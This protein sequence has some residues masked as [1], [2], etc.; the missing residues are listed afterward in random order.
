MNSPSASRK[1]HIKNGI[2]FT[3]LYI[4]TIAIVASVFYLTPAQANDFL[5]FR[6]I[7]IGFATVLLAKYFVYMVASPWYDVVLEL[8]FNKQERLFPKRAYEPR[9]SV[10]VPAWNEED[11]VITTVHA[12]LDSSYRNMEIIVID[13]ASTDH[14]DSNV[15]HLL[16]EYR[17]TMRRDVPHIDLVYIHEEKQGKG[18]ALN[19]GIQRATGDILVTID[20]DCYV[21]PRS[22]EHF[23]RYFEDPTTMAAVGNVRIGNAET[24]LGLV[25]YLEFLF[26]F[27]FKKADSLFG[28]IYIIGGAA[29]AFRKEVFQKIG[30]FDAETITE[31]IDLSIRIQAAGMKIVYAPDALIYTEGA[32]DFRGLLR[33]RLRWK[34][35]RFEAFRKHYRLFFSTDG[36]HNKFLCWMILPLAIFGDLQLSLELPFLA[37]LYAYSYLTKDYSSFISGI[38]VVCSM[39]VVQIAFDARKKVFKRLILLAP[40][41]WLLLYVTTF[42]EVSALVRAFWGYARGNRLGWQQ[43]KRHGVFAK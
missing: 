18:N 16:K 38:V 29:G 10:L 30:G 17:R 24:L 37:F 36:R 14:T 26:S 39:F 34:R 11:G 6:V 21:S 22:I 41:G 28:S 19:K 27:Y 40:I 9:V 1:I 31:D 4:A 12:L 13:N 33:Q 15:R 32:A 8:A 7:I 2:I 25:Q 23:V 35:G 43:W 20:A 5:V 42:V 3:L